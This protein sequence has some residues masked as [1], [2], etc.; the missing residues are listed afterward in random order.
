MVCMT[1]IP[2]LGYESTPRV[3]RFVVMMVIMRGVCQQRCVV[4]AS[5]A[6]FS[7]TGCAGP[8]RAP[9][10]IIEPAYNHND[11]AEV[12]KQPELIDAAPEGWGE[13]AI[14]REPDDS[15]SLF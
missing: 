11:Q 14:A 6:M 2:A 15:T 10:V 9:S 5:C 1:W 8:E 12:H 13:D 3:G 4:L 7:A